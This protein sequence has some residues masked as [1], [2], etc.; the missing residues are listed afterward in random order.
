MST[1]PRV[2]DIFAMVI[3]FLLGAIFW[4][5]IAVV[6]RFALSDTHNVHPFMMYYFIPVFGLPI[7][8]IVTLLH[9][10]ASSF[11]RYEKNSEWLAA[12]LLYSTLFVFFAFPWAV[13]AAVL[14]NPITIRL[15][16][17]DR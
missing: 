16:T 4:V 2:S 12:G 7:L 5:T 9:L 17:R 13:V 8:L 14:I 1:T 3:A 10:L 6:I 15:A 11:F